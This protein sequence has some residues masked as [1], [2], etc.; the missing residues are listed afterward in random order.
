[1]SNGD[2]S[3]MQA[4]LDAMRIKCIVTEPLGFGNGMI[5]AGY[6][7]N[8]ETEAEK[9]R[10]FIKPIN[11]GVPSGCIDGRKVLW[12]LDRNNNVELRPCVAGGAGIT[13]YAAAELVGLFSDYDKTSPAE[14]YE[15]TVEML[16][17]RTDNTS[18]SVV[19]GGHCDQGALTSNFNEGKTGCGA[20]DQFAINI[21]NLGDTPII[22]TDKEGIVHTE[23]NEEIARRLSFIKSTLI[24][25]LGELFDEVAYSEMIVRAGELNHN[26]TFDKW[27]GVSM[28]EVLRKR[29]DRTITVLEDDHRG[30]HGHR[31]WL[32]AVNMIPETTIDQN[33]YSAASDDKQVFDVDGW[34]IGKLADSLTDDKNTWLAL[35]QAGLAYQ[36]GTYYTLANGTQRAAIYSL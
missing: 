34:Y 18:H 10:E 27:S 26:G 16:E 31:E 6:V 13:A 29:G 14:R 12:T 9:V 8:P 23:T 15:L 1:M 32:V 19:P 17:C 21:A 25:I 33:A 24:A 2:P 22:Y 30:V 4:E 3:I 7:E 5:D 20:A 35:R 28:I 11:N 36:L